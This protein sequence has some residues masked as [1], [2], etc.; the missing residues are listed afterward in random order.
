[1]LY[2]VTTMA[3]TWHTVATRDVRLLKRQLDIVNSL[4]KEYV[5]LNYLR[6]HDDIGW[7]LDYDVLLLDGIGERSHKQYLN[8]YFQGYAG[9]SNS[10]GELYNADPVTGDAR[11]C[12]TTASMCGLEKALFEKN[13]DAAERA[14]RL[15]LM[16]HAYMFM[17][18]GI[19]VLY[20]GD[21]IG[22][23]NDYSYKEDP[24]KAA[25]SRYLHRGPMNWE[26]AD[27]RKDAG[28]VEGKIFKGLSRLEQ[29]R[30]TERVFVSEA[31]A[32]TIETWDPSI[33]CIGRYYDGE[34]MIGIFNFSE[35]DKTAWIHET[36]G[37]YVE[38]IS[39]ADK[40]PD[41]V[42]IPAYGF[43][44]MKKKQDITSV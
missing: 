44:Y 12:G 35:Y 1:M 7:G 31:D 18:S 21:E 20:S 23:L 5:F 36:D 32:W 37:D 29:I 11:F 16:L 39:G 13:E 41:S 2:N 14:V 34:K 19:P 10:R 24:N 43:Y 3:T 27:K 6:C 26:L 33:L 38:L 42:D 4:P 40:N 15:V 17:Q 25:D 28:T 30:K 9:G 22:Q 8:D